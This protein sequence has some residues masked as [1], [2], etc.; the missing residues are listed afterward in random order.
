MMNTMNTIYHS[1][2]PPLR[3]HSNYRRR[4]APAPPNLPM[5]G[6]GGVFGDMRHVPRSFSG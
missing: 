1:S 3:S 4:V 6:G 2:S 5:G